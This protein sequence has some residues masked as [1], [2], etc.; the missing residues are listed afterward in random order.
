MFMGGVLISYYVMKPSQDIPQSHHRP[1]PPPHGG[2]GMQQFERAK[3]GLSAEGR[4][5]VDE[6]LR[7]KAKDMREGLHPMNKL[8]DDARRALTAKNFDEKFLE[9]I[10]QE[11]EDNNSEI[12]SHLSETVHEIAVGLSSEDRILFFEQ[13]LPPSLSKRR[14]KF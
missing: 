5:L 1:P 4:A 7:K 14:H 8:R 12:K 10:H 9:D 6:V 13:A 11:M 2:G 3:L